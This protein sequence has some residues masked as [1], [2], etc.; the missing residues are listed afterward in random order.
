M[1]SRPRPSPSLRKEVAERA[2]GLCEYCRSSDSFASGP[3]ESEHIIPLSLNGP[4]ELGNLAW[5]CGGC[6]LFKS[7]KT[8]AFDPDSGETV[9][10]Y[11]PR[12]D[13]W[14]AHFYWSEDYLHILAT[15][16]KARTTIAALRMNRSSLINLRRA[17]I[18]I[19]HHPPDET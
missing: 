8:E 2:K 5:A 4:T 11:H 7:N 19:G 1:A 13:E 6:N 17:L 14:A 3:F 9:E 18:A 12:N 15:S 16:R 10:L